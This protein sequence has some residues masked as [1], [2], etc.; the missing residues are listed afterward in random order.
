MLDSA[1]GLPLANDKLPIRQHLRQKSEQI[2]QV[3]LSEFFPLP[4]PALLLS[5][6]LF[7]TLLP[8]KEQLQKHIQG[9]SEVSFWIQAFSVPVVFSPAVFP[10][11]NYVRY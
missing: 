3:R 10:V 5:V 2:S 8:N 4:E 9:I 11:Q 7:E 1:A 6:L